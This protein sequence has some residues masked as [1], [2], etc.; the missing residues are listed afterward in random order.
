[1][2]KKIVGVLVVLSVSLYANNVPNILDDYKLI[3]ELIDDLGKK[4]GFNKK[5]QVVNDEKLLLIKESQNL[6]NDEIILI[7]ESQKEIEQKMLLNKSKNNIQGLSSITVDQLDK[8]T[9]K[10]LIDNL[11]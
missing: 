10:K 5:A 6:M 9:R 11:R 1:M 3:I 4:I 8:T 2:K 7:K